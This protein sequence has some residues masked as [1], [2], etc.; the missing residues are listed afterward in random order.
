[1]HEGY[2]TGLRSRRRNIQNA[3]AHGCDVARKQ[4]NDTYTVAHA[5]YTTSCYQHYTNTTTHHRSKASG[6]QA[7]ATLSSSRL[8]P[9]T[10]MNLECVK[11]APSTTSTLNHRYKAPCCFGLLHPDSRT[12]PVSGVRLPGAVSLPGTGVPRPKISD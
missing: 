11:T 2:S 8:Q 7:G 6:G 10:A 3:Y 9:R 1:M 12:G 5:V 4:F